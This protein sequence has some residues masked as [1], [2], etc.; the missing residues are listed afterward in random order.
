MPTEL[1]VLLVTAATIG[2]VHTLL[3]PDHYVP[4]I[5]LARARSWSLGHT[6]R[7]TLVCGVGHVLGSVALGVIGVALGLGVSHIEAIE[8]TRGELAAWLL[9][10]L[11]TL[12]MAWGIHQAMRQHAHHHHGPHVHHLRRTTTGWV[13]FIVFVLGPCEA[14]I[15]VLMYPAAT[16]GMFEMALVTAVFAAATLLTMC[17]VVTFGLAGMQLLAFSQM[18]RYAH[19]IAGATILA[20]GLGIRFLGL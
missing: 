3:G 6:L 14:L 17:A 8:S 15:P 1:A 9:I 12:Y 16:A 18:E 11:G 2:V 4:F 10:T 7:W 19:A 5:A 13:L 20:C